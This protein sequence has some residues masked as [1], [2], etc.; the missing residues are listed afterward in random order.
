MSTSK[1]GASGRSVDYND[2]TK[3]PGRDRLIAQSQS[4]QQII[5]AQ[6]FNDELQ[7]RNLKNFKPKVPGKTLDE[8]NDPDI[9]NNPSI[10]DSENPQDKMKES[11]SNIK[12]NILNSFENYSYNLKLFLAKETAS[13]NSMESEDIIV[14]AESGSTATFSI[15]ECEIE[16][17]I[18]PN[19]RTKNTTVTKIR[20]KITEPLGSTF[21]DRI[22]LAC[23]SLGV[24][25][26]LRAPMWIEVS[27][28]GYN[29]A[30]DDSFSNGDKIL[31]TESRLY[32]VSVVGTRAQVTSGG[33]EYDMDLVPTNEI[34]FQDQFSRLEESV[35]I[36]ASTIG[37]FFKKLSKKLS[38]IDNYSIENIR[39]NTYPAFK[40]IKFEAPVTG[41]G[42]DMFTKNG[43]GWKLRGD[44]KFNKIRSEAWPDAEQRKINVSVENGKTMVSFNR[45][46]RI[47]AIIE[48]VL[49]STIE[50][51]SYAILG[52]SSGI[53][54]HKSLSDG[55]NPTTPA[56]IFT[57]DPTLTYDTYNSVA[58]EYNKTVTFNIRSYKTFQPM[59]S[60]NQVQSSTN[61]TERTNAIMKINNIQKRYEYIYTGL[62]T[63][64]LDFKLTFDRAWFVQLPIFLGQDRHSVSSGST[65]TVDVPK[66]TPG[67]PT[68]DV[69]ITTAQQP[70]S[71]V[72]K[73]QRLEQTNV[74]DQSNASTDD[75]NP[76]SEE[77]ALLNRINSPQ[78]SQV[79][80]N[81]TQT[82]TSSFSATNM[83]TTSN[84][85]TRFVGTGTTR[86][87]S[88]QVN[89]TSKSNKGTIYYAEDLDLISV[90]R[91]QVSGITT[92]PND[93]IRDVKAHV[94]TTESISE[95]NIEGTAGLG[96]SFFSAV[97]GQAYGRQ[98]DMITVTM[99]I[100]G[101]P[102]W[103]GEPNADQRK[104]NNAQGDLTTSQS[105][106][107]FT[108]AFP[109]I[110][111]DQSSGS[112]VDSHSGTG[113]VNINRTQNGF[114]GIY[115]VR[116]V[117]NMFSGG[118]FTQKLD[119]FVDPLTREQDVI[120]AV[121]LIGTTA[122]S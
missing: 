24:K 57:V 62:N 88:S 73:K 120:Q 77:L 33:T 26:H 48:Q 96:R 45:G 66:L 91:T 64:I 112:N 21:Y 108:M 101:D 81:P 27:F 117:I 20:M 69:N 3:F 32:R 29:G 43:V 25:D 114:N 84:D 46:T 92:D 4:K 122:K 61:N 39:T 72:N 85:I 82:N 8:S 13:I 36:S 110:P 22:R 83:L 89:N 113:L 95:M 107:L 19:F 58:K 94:A 31:R 71:N 76:S 54:D 103:M 67:S 86:N 63:E 2:P 1:N 102:Y 23:K 97:L 51:Q 42:S 11:V 12:E 34:A 56:V 104:L 75:S 52:E 74:V 98:S 116:R 87:I 90:N 37:E 15:D 6:I 106:F 50:G 40:N 119:A 35:N 14:L 53:E 65:S 105:M 16:N 115:Q 68:T 60:A 109:T 111:D 79:A 28:K 47:E 100:R 18:S 9:A 59:V 44:D 118:R 80:F 121:N 5:A 55:R 7:D 49:S 17:I 70:N 93:H 78:V 30:G 41:P 10:T 38:F 99:E